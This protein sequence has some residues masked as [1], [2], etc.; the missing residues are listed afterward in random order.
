MPRGSAQSSGYISTCRLGLRRSKSGCP[1]ADRYH[2]P[3]RRGWLVGLFRWL[4]RASS[5]VQHAQ[6]ALGVL[7]WAGLPWAVGIS[8][9]I[10][11]IPSI[12]A[13]VDNQPWYWTFSLFVSVFAGCMLI[14][15]VVTY[16]RLQEFIVPAEPGTGVSVESPTPAIELSVGTKFDDRVAAYLAQPV[17]V[18]SEGFSWERGQYKNGA[19]GTFPK[20]PEHKTR[21]LYRYREH[22]TSDRWKTLEPYDRLTNSHTDQYSRAHGA[23]LFCSHEDGHSLGWFADSE[24]FGDAR[25]RAEM[26]IKQEIRRRASV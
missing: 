12:A 6:L 15:G 23:H 19:L 1:Q 18:T 20:C 10:S 5:A 17:E 2:P 21:L 25:N 14:Y 24:S 7:T 11:G 26:L 9:I 3:V 8:A 16:L 4:L 13:L 22:A